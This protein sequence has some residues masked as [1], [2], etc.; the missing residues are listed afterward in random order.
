MITTVPIPAKK[1]ADDIP[2]NEKVMTLNRG[3]KTWII[4]DTKRCGPVNHRYHI[5]WV[6][7]AE[8]NKFVKQDKEQEKVKEY[9]EACFIVRYNYL[10]GTPNSNSVPSD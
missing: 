7:T 2:M 3:P 5:N 9:L 1:Y 4:Y 10:L 8:L 6:D